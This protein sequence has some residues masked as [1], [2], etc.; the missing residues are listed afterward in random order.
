MKI[1]KCRA[2]ARDTSDQLTTDRIELP[3]SKLAKYAG[4]IDE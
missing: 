4:E 1:M 3:V 2:L